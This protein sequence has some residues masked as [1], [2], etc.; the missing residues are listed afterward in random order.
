MTVTLSAY[1]AYMYSLIRT[2][3][4]H[5]KIDCKCY[6]YLTTF[7]PKPCNDYTVRAWID[8]WL[9]CLWVRESV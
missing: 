3:N 2:S 1:T 6:I 5:D 9:V 7:L 8:N 4:I